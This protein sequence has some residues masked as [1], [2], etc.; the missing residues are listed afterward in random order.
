[1]MKR[2]SHNKFMTKGHFD[3]ACEL[4]SFTGPNSEIRSIYKTLIKK[5]KSDLFKI[6]DQTIFTKIKY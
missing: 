6:Y 5:K 3:L 4:R 2:E 1:M